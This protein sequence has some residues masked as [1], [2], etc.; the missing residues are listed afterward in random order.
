MLGKSRLL[1]FLLPG[2][3]PPDDLPRRE[4]PATD[5]PPANLLP[6]LAET[7]DVLCVDVRAGAGLLRA[8][9]EL[10]RIGRVERTCRGR[11]WCRAAST[12]R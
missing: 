6:H 4:V 1:C 7:A 5:V 3:M 8:R 12:R 9:A 10:L 2:G 11:G